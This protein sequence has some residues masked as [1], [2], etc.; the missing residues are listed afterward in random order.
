MAGH[1]LSDRALQRIGQAVKR[2]EQ[3]PLE[4]GAAGQMAQPPRHEVY[5]GKLDAALSAGGSAIVSLWEFTTGATGRD[6]GRNVTAY[7]YFL[8]SGSLD[9]NTK[10]KVEWIGGRW[11]VTAASC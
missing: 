9:A 4:L 5:L 1:T 6:T 2:V 8:A 7:D 11:F 10:V 3:M